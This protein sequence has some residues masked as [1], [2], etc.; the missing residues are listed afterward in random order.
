MRKSDLCAERQRRLE[1][2]PEV[3]GVFAL[4]PPPIPANLGQLDLRL[5]HEAMEQAQEALGRLS[6]T[7]QLLPV[8]ELITRSLARREA[9]ASSQIEGTQAGVGDILEY[10]VTQDAAS[11]PRDTR[12]TL[13]YVLALEYGLQAVA[14]RG[15]DALDLPLIQA[16]HQQLM[17]HAQDYRDPPGALRTLQ[18]WIGGLRI[19]DARFVPPRPERVQEGLED[20]VR[21][22]LQYA[23]ESNAHAGIVLRAGV[24]HAQ[25]ET[26][27]PFRDGNGRTGRLLVSLML[28]AEGYPPLYLAGPLFRHQREYFDGLLGVQLRSEW[29]V[30]MRFFAQA[31]TEACDTSIA[32]AQGLV[33]VRESWQMRLPGLRRDAAAHRLLERL[34]GTPVLTADSARQL[35]GCSFPAANNA[36]KQLVGAGI[37]QAPERQRNRV[38]IAHE[39]ITLLQQR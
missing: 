17:A 27:H 7:A 10:E 24:A 1:P 8:P 11:L 31:L 6:A 13:D 34:I 23:P 4:H 33:N 26:L 37:L 32:L 12:N 21:Q 20:L 14:R 35:L 9:V 5:A 28:A 2:V 22:I 15:C 36:L 25:F 30:W 29:G 16:L 18:N 38:F 19:Q 39:V 3:P